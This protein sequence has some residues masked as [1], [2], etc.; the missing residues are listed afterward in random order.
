MIKIKGETDTTIVNLIKDEKGNIIEEKSVRN[1][2]S[3]PSIY[4]YYDNDGRLTDIVRYNK[5]PGDCCQTTFSSIIPI[6]FLRCFLF[7][8]PQQITKNG[9]I[10]TQKTD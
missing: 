4:Y 9:Y 8:Q 10:S 3:L 7:L 2:Q 5:K 1:G 6:V